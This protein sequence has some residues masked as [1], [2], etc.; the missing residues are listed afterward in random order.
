MSTTLT[1]LGALLWQ[2]EDGLGAGPRLFVD[3]QAPPRGWVVRE[4]YQV[5]NGFDGPSYLLPLDGSAAARAR[6]LLAYNDL[7]Y[8]KR[9]LARR[10][11][12]IG[13][14]TGLLRPRP[15]QVAVVAAPPGW[16]GTD[17]RTHLAG[18]LD[19]APNE[20]LL[21][22]AVRVAA[23]GLR[24]TITVT[25]RAGTPISFVKVGRGQVHARRLQD[26]HVAL[27]AVRDE[28]AGVHTP[29]P[30]SFADWCGRAVLAVEP[31]PSDIVRVDLRDD[32][33]T[34]DALADLRGLGG[35]PAA[36]RESAW[37]QTTRERIRA[38]PA[39]RGERL[40]DRL[41]A[42]EDRHGDGVL[43]MAR[44]H[45]DWSPWNLA[46]TAS[47]RLVAWDWEFSQPSAPW[48]L[49]QLNWHFAV[50]TSHFDRDPRDAVDRLRG[51]ADESDDLDASLIDLF[52]LDQAVRRAEEARVSDPASL[53]LSA[54]L[55]TLL[56]EATSR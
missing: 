34:W 24:P 30:Q 48:G 47:G 46:R 45:G 1:A 53:A 6:L 40:E 18:V 26:E 52:V 14:R 4:R 22:T 27:S 35:P 7:R 12:A 2:P 20:L 25:D 51:S 42:C 13:I 38:L 37:A 8:L 10:G 5:V 15:H 39:A 55:L 43:E 49:D 56:D 36:L 41:R 11:V 31:L 9:R 50:E 32:R 17:L 33:S 29:A 19:R 54:E 23:G 21:G 16:A 28:L 44:R 3:G